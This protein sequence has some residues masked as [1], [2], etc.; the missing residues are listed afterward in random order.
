MQQRN[1]KENGQIVSE[2]IGDINGTLFTYLRRKAKERD[3]E[4]SITKQYL[5]DL[6]VAQQGKC[7][8]TGVDLF[9][10]STLIGNNKTGKRLDRTKHTASLDRINNDVGYV[11]GNLQWIHKTINKMRR[12]YS[13]DEYIYWCKLVANHAN[14]EPTPQN[15]DFVCGKVQRLT[16]EESTNNPDTSAGHP[17]R[18]KI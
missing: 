11:V 15:D 8:L 14:I 18:M 17:T 1:R 6:F 10:S 16:G 7:A 5:W 3:L 12:E 4:F 9:I 2:Q 13:I